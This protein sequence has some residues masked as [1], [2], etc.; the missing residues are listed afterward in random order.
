MHFSSVL[1]SFLNT[2]L[3]ICC[4]FC[5]KQY[6]WPGIN[7]RLPFH[8]FN[9]VFIVVF[10]SIAIPFLLNNIEYYSGEKKH[11]PL[12]ILVKFFF[13]SNLS[14]FQ[15]WVIIGTSAINIL[16][17]KKYKEDYF[18]IG[19]PIE[20]KKPQPITTAEEEE[21]EQVEA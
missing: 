1:L 14:S 15:Q 13:G 18:N 11:T 12:S 19:I 20:H 10:Y 17:I 21:E 7:I 4:L 16:Y 6:F 8:I 5:I 3:F 9:L 2:I